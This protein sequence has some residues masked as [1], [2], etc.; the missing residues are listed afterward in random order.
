MALNPG[1][2]AGKCKS[3]V[4]SGEISLFVSA[5]ILAEVAEVLKRPVFRQ[6]AP[7]LT[8]ERVEA[9]VEEIAALSISISNVPE[10]FHYERDPADEPYIN[11]ALVTDARYLVSLDRDLL[12]L[13]DTIVR[14]R[15]G[16]SAALSDAQSRQ[17]CQSSRRNQKSTSLIVYP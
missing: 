6:L 16:I 4:E 11:L 3:L 1:G 17:A 14:R 12:D 8:P 10:E 13:M 5:T 7:D 2:P 9:L 15:S